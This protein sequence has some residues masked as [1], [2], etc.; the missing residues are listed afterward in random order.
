M[1]L[2]IIRLLNKQFGLKNGF[3]FYYQMF[4]IYSF[5]VNLEHRCFIDC[6]LISLNTVFISHHLHYQSKNN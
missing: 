4:K 3:K 2:T 1:F 5:V 6:R